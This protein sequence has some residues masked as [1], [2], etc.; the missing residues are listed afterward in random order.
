MKKLLASVLL[1]GCGSLGTALAGEIGVGVVFSDDEIRIISAWYRDHGGTTHHGG[2]KSKQKGLPPGIEKNLARGKPL[3]PGIAKKVARGGALPPGIAKKTL[4]N[5]L[6]SRLPARPG[7][8]WRV[9]GT[10]VL[11]VEIATG[12]IVDVLKDAL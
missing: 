7:Q 5:G 9:V 3:P 11:I 1:I 2:G 4:P 6:L 12:I 10:D 8:E